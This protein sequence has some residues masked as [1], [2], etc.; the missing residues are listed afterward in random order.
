MVQN[1]VQGSGQPFGDG[2]REQPQEKTETF[3]PK[4][5]FLK[6]Q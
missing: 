1:Q 2:G 6:K 4:N 3:R 5:F